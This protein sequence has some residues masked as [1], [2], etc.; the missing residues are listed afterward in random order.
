MISPFG[1]DHGGIAKY[2]E[3]RPSTP[4]EI[5]AYKARVLGKHPKLHPLKRRRLDDPRTRYSQTANSI[6]DNGSNNGR[7]WTV[8]YRGAHFDESARQLKPGERGELI[9]K[10]IILYDAQNRPIARNRAVQVDGKWMLQKV[11]LGD[12]PDQPPS[13]RPPRPAP[14]P[15]R[16]LRLFA[17]RRGNT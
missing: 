4:A 16:R 10:D 2:F 6:V 14:R 8:T 9:Q 15:R 3:E 1:V 13:A 17:R 11:P 5:A 7:G 12:V